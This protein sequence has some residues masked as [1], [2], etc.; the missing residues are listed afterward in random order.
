MAEAGIDEAGRGPVFGPLVVA[1]VRS[2][3]P[4]K[5]VEMEVADSK[6]I[7]AARRERMARLI[8][9]EPTCQHVVIFRS[10]EEIDKLRENQ[11]LNEI[12]VDMFK[13]AFAALDDTKT[14]WFLD[15]ADVDEER[16]GRL[17]SPD[18]PVVSKHGADDKYVVVGAASI[19]AKVERDNAMKTLQKRLERKL[20]YNVG[21]GYPSDPSTKSFLA[22]YVEKFGEF[23]EG[24]RT[25]WKTAK[26]LIPK[27]PSSTLADF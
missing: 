19:I 18:K 16:F 14:K 6:K 27:P 11:T 25:S 13:E 15:A 9:D 2:T 4:E 23:P 24:T 3:N 1:A 26:R 10:A 7:P 17:V 12:E 20:P 8:R 5:L 22:A 21:S